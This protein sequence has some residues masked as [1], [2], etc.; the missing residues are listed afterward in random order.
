MKFAAASRSASNR[1]KVLELAGFDLIL[2]KIVHV[3]LPFYFG[4]NATGGSGIDF[5]KQCGGYQ[6]FNESKVTGRTHT[7]PPMTEEEAL[8]RIR[9]AV[10][11]RYAD[12]G[13]HFD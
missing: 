13:V 9:K 11:E 1:W 3:E 12:Q 7:Q 10:K 4:R 8:A 5:C 2:A 6:Y